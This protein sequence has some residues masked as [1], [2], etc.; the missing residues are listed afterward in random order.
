MPNINFNFVLGYVRR[1]DVNSISDVSEI[2]AASMFRMDSKD[3]VSMYSYLWNDDNAIHM[4]A[5]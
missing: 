5:V 4:Y 1:V 3:R 2:H